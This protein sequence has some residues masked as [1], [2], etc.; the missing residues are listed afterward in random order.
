MANILATNWRLHV[1]SVKWVANSLAYRAF[2][3]LAERAKREAEEFSKLPAPKD[4]SEM[5]LS[6]AKSSIMQGSWS[7]EFLSR[8]ALHANAEM[9]ASTQKVLDALLPQSSAPN[10]G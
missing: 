2:P 10:S 3:E 7:N 8:A 9:L 6:I 1:D 4:P 5:A